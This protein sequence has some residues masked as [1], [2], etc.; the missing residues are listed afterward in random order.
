MC[1]GNCKFR[2]LEGRGTLTG[3]VGLQ[4]DIRFKTSARLEAVAS[5]YL[6]N[7]EKKRSKADTAV[8]VVHDDSPGMLLWSTSVDASFM[9]C[10]DGIEVDAKA[11]YAVFGDK[12]VALSRNDGEILWT[13]DHGGR[14][15][16]LLVAEGSLYAQIAGLEIVGTEYEFIAAIDTATGDLKWANQVGGQVRGPLLFHEN[17]IYYVEMA[18]EVGDPGGYSRLMAFDVSTGDLNWQYRIDEESATGVVEADG[19]IYLH[20]GV[21][22]KNFLYVFDPTEKALVR[23]YETGIA[24]SSNPLIYDG[25]AYVVSEEGDLHSFNL[26]DGT[27]NW[28]SQTSDKLTGTPLQVD[29]FVFVPETGE[30]GETS[31]FLYGMVVETGQS[32]WW[33]GI[34]TKKDS[35]AVSGKYVYT[36]VFDYLRASDAAEIDM[37]WE[38]R[39]G[40]ICGPVTAHD[41]ALYGRLLRDGEHTVIALR[42]D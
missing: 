26:S 39:Y 9:E 19:Y 14:V 12:L 22:G 18:G 24:A 11:V 1:G 28:E 20:T 29:R 17:E 6:Q 35:V 31:R 16:Y 34:S 23:R 25:S 33:F 4:S 13:E 5:W 15:S 8:E 32:G 30:E 38:A 7:S 3:Q 21:S 10:G 37:I 27:Q 36:N 42:G 2:S 40:E 41:G